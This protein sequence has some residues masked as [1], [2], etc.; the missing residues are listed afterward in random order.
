MAADRQSEELTAERA[1]AAQAN[2]RAAAAEADAAAARKAV[3][4]VRAE[5]EDA[6]R[7]QEM[8]VARYAAEAQLLRERLHGIE[9]STVWRAGGPL[10]GFG[11]KHPRAARL[12]RRGAKIAW[13]TASGQIVQ[14][15]RARR[16]G[17]MPIPTL[18]AP[19]QL[20][21][22]DP[23]AA[24][25]A[26]PAEAGSIRV[27]GSLRPFVS[28]VVPT[29]GQ[30]DF[31][32][33]CL[34]SIA[35]HPLRYA[36]E[37]IVMDDA[38]P[39]P[40]VARLRDEVDGIRLV[41]NEHNLGFLKTCNAAAMLA[42]GDHILF[43]NND[44][45]VAPGAVDVLADL[46]EADPKVG[47]A[48]SKLVYP[49]GR[50][51]EAGG[52]MWDD[53]SGWNWG[54]GEDPHRPEY[55][56][57]REVDYISGAAIMVRRSAFEALGGFDPAFAPA[58]YEDV[59]IAF[60]L[61]EAG[62][63]VVYEPRSVVI[64]HEGASHGT[65]TSSGVKAY[66]VT[67]SAR[68]RERWGDVLRRDHLPNGAP[69]LRARDRARHRNVVL[70]A[71]HYVPEPDRD[72]GS[73]VVMSMFAALVELGWIVKFWPQN[74]AYSETYTPPLEAMGVEV[75]DWRS[76]MTL[77]AWL[78][79]NG[80]SLD[81][82]I[83][84]RP[85]VAVDLLPAILG[86]TPARLAYYGVDIHFERMRRQAALSGD[87]ALAR[88]AEE[89]RRLETRLWRSFDPVIHLSEEEAAIV[90]REVP[91]A[92]AKTVL[93]FP[94]ERV[95]RRDAPTE[96]E[97]ILFVAGFMH[98]PNVDAARVLI[99]EV[100]PIVRARR[101]G[102]RVCLVGS[103]PTV[104]VRALAGPKVEV[105]GWVSAE[106]LRE[107]YA[108][109][110][111]A[112]VPLRFGA[113]VK[114]KVAEALTEGVP[115]VTTSIGA[116]GFCGLSEVIP[117][118]ADTAS[119]AA[120]IVLLLEDDAAW[121]ARSEAG[122]RF[123]EETLSTAATRETMALAIGSGSRDVPSDLDVEL[124]SLGEWRALREARP[125]LLDASYAHAIALHGAAHG[126]TNGI[127]G[128]SGPE[129]VSVI[130]TNHR[131][132]FLASDLNARQRAV[133]DRLAL[134]PGAEYAHALR[135]YAHE[136]LTPLGL[137]LRGRY[138]FFLGSEYAPDEASARAI[139]P[140]PH[141]DIM[142]SGLP[143]ATFDA[144]LTNEVLEHVP[145]LQAALRDTAR[146]LKPGGRLI[147]TFP[148]Q[149]EREETEIKAVL[150]DGAP[151]FL[152]TPEYHGNPVDPEG[153]SL[154]FQVPAWDVL[155]M[156][157]EAGFRDARIIFSSSHARGITGAEV[158]GIFVFEAER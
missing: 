47:L 58:Y 94:C 57:R 9:V 53:A 139:F 54:R 74:R 62:L 91:G 64:H 148:F 69:P 2:Q 106:R 4:V 77:A 59:D 119:M 90:R 105:T 133:L 104:E 51:Q 116:E 39:G 28:I 81:L 86:G 65:D 72:A 132:S 11:S 46:L 131:E 48:G 29:Y 60:R 84:T 50:L 40:E 71:D 16:A 114:G 110:R 10:R 112:V 25:P 41:R 44:T 43:L 108:E 123:A 26:L 37:V 145:D 85:M 32:L 101:P 13:W 98:P 55:N 45:E 109:A 99:E 30:V 122:T 56:Y 23:P 124:R 118:H 8:E 3:D 88:D 75:L 89:M 17:A 138:A 129:K 18:P 137:L 92:N 35:A 96:G 100:M 130:G 107:H 33:R 1:R 151:H 68:M 93:G 153:G 102:A 27:P 155:E 20:E 115:L 67:N 82:V 49:D 34:A 146:I 149:Y 70:F 136:G 127:V 73:R 142:R 141:V 147:G 78:A 12:V 36:I 158:A 52:I 22:T 42:R 31:T 157:R 76:P 21:D 97:T 143:N 83:L 14:R 135:L 150:R 38:Y 126:V 120:D 95:V 103:N 121:T 152:T 117:I 5:A 125:E 140:I 79:E 111:V 7:R 128:R 19:L 156:A 66:Q 24:A 80:T 61:R 63:S 15:V 113:G 6:A 144:V 87:A 154:V 134:M